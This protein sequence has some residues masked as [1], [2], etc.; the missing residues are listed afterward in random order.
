MGFFDGIGRRLGLMDRMAETVGADVRAEGPVVYRE[1]VMRCAQCG[2][3]ESC[4]GWLDRHESAEAAPSYCRNKDLLEALA[5][6]A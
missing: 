1:A 6:K 5:V 2:S 4:K 3:P